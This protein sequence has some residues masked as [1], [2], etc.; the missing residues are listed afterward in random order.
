MDITVAFSQN[1]RRCA[2]IRNALMACNGSQSHYHY[3]ADNRSGADNLLCGDDSI[4]WELIPEAD[5]H[6]GTNDNYTIYITERPFEDNWFSHEEVSVSVIT[7]S[8]WERY[9]APPSLQ[10]YLAYQIA[11]ASICAEAQLTEEMEIRLC[12]TASNGCMFD[13]CV[14]KRDIKLGM[15]AGIIC[16]SCQAALRQYGLDDVAL[17]ATSRI[18]RYVRLTTIG[19]PSLVRWND[20]FVVMKYTTRDANDHAYR[21]GIKPAI[22]EVGLR[23]IR[24]DEQPHNR[25]VLDTVRMH[26]RQ[27]RFTIVKIDE[28]NLNVYF[29]LGYAMALDKDIILVCDEE[30]VQQLPTDINNF[31]CVTYPRGDY[32][33]LRNALTNVFRDNYRVKLTVV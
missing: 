22:E 10:S 4:D 17:E 3:I 31:V 33:S 15:S 19:V 14:D 7:T 2:Q 26:I 27:S 11:Q 18:L 29:E 25:T 8:S 9:Y 21:Y 20:A 32:E 30:L 13:M 5:N 1:H 6:A 24:A 12:H 23:C 16:P 28:P